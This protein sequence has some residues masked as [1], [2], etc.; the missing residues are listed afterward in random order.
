M[1]GSASV[2]SAGRDDVNE[3]AG[4][5]TS[6]KSYRLSLLLLLGLFDGLCLV[7]A[8]KLGPRIMLILLHELSVS[9]HLQDVLASGLHLHL[10]SL[11]PLPHEA[12]LISFVC[13]LPLQLTHLREWVSNER[14]D[15]EHSRWR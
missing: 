8:T 7:V 15:M 1:R 12:D 13:L 2:G 9:H 3:C 6:R 14:V 5:G 4:N 11:G 10:G